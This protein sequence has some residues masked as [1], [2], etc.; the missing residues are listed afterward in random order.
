MTSYYAPRHVQHIAELEKRFGPVSDE[1]AVALRSLVRV[2]CQYEDPV[3]A[4]PFLERCLAIEE[5]L[6]GP[7]V[8]LSDL[9]TW[10][11]QAGGVDFEYVEPLQ[12]RRLAVKTE[13]FGEASQEVAA[14]EALAQRYAWSG[15]YSKARAFLE[16]SIAIK[17]RLHGVLSAEVVAAVDLLAE[18]SARLKRWE[19]AET[20]LQR[21]RELKEKIF[22]ARSEEVARSLL[23][24]AI[25]FANAS[26]LQQT[27]TRMERVRKAAAAFE[28]GLNQLEERLGPDSHQVQKALEAMAGAYVDCRE[29]RQA[30]PLL[31]RLLAK[32]E[33]AHGRD[34]AALLWILA[35]LA[36]G[37]ANDGSEKAEPVLERSFELL[38]ALLDAKKPIFPSGIRNEVLYGGSGGG[39]LEKLVRASETFRSNLRKRWGA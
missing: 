23:T 15:T 21:G 38:R 19:D 20:Y 10:I 18:T 6:H 35:E 16:R 29:F 24:S 8:T 37:Y 30:E 9:N 2:I 13:V 34:A 36:E 26:K 4:I 7:E 27:G 12:L 14:C 31:K 3:D 33:R 11:G 1:V 25:V 5:A 22:G 17:E 32:S 39:V 28:L